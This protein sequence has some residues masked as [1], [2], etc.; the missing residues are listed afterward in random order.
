MADNTSR[1]SMGNM[2]QPDGRGES[3]ADL[4]KD[5]RDEATLLVRQEVALA[6]TE[7]SEKMARIL[8]NTVYAIA[9]ALVAFVGVIFILQAATVAIG[10]GLHQAGLTEKQSLWASP[11]ILGVIVAIVG[12]VLISKGIAAVKSESLVPEKTMESLNNDKKWIQ[13]KTR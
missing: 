3:I 9:G 11:L 4:I 7:I 12:T 8:R 1:Q 10:I 5:L 13:N 2:A 6:K